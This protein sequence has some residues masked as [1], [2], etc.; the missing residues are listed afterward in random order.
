MKIL[1]KLLR[2]AL[3]VEDEAWDEVKSERDK[4]LHELTDELE[5]AKTQLA[6]EHTTDPNPN[7]RAIH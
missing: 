5:Q 6:M 3:R 1:R 7:L 4:A 2:K